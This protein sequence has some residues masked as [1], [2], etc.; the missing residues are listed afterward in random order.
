[1]EKTKKRAL[2]LD[3]KDNVCILLSDAAKNDIVSLKGKNGDLQ[4]SEDIEFGHKAA[5][6]SVDN[7]EEI[8]KYGQKIGVAAQSI[9]KGQ[10]IHLHNMKSI[11][12]PD[13]RK[14]I[15]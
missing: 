3:S 8:I 1:M 13:F 2:V 9:A 11:V 10:W 12:D 4:L 7:G 14:R 15:I 6:K 5:L